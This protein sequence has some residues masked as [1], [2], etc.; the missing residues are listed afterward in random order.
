M[1]GQRISSREDI[2]ANRC[3]GTPSTF[4]LTRLTIYTIIVLSEYLNK[5]TNEMIRMIYTISDEC[6]ST[7]KP[8][9]GQEDDFFDGMQPRALVIDISLEVLEIRKE[10]TRD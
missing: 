7:I 3:T 8:E 10:E 5:N 2:F 1:R 9:K 4:L 6:P